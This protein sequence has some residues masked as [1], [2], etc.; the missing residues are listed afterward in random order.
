MSDATRRD[1]TRRDATWKAG[2]MISRVCLHSARRDAT[3][4][5]K[6]SWRQL[7]FCSRVGHK[8]KNK[9]AFVNPEAYFEAYDESSPVSN[10]YRQ[11]QSTITTVL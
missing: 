10:L 5:D 8:N 3:R 1:A 11:I 9:D 6:K 2:L 7:N 4:R